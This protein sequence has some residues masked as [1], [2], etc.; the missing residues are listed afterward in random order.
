MGDSGPVVFIPILW[1]RTPPVF[2]V[3]I[4]QPLVISLDFNILIVISLNRG[5]QETHKR[6]VIEQHQHLLILGSLARLTRPI[7]CHDS[8]PSS[9]RTL[10]HPVFCCRKIDDIKLFFT[11][12]PP[13]GN[14]NPIVYSFLLLIVCFFVICMERCVIPPEVY[15]Y[16]IRWNLI[17]F[18]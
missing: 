13:F 6:F 8:L 1:H 4:A 7:N 5:R 14:L 12:V 10:D 17:A 9:G 3:H 2:T 11:Q 15:F 18:Q 16:R